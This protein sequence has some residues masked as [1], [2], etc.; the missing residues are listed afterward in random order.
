[1]KD[2]PILSSVGIVAVGA[3]HPI[4]V[5]MHLVFEYTFRIVA[6]ETQLLPGE[7]E[8]LFIFRLV[9]IMARRTVSSSHGAVQVFIGGTQVLVTHIAKVWFRFQHVSERLLIMT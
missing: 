4:Q 3:S 9:W 8:Q 1:M 2:K 5:V 6:V 7:P